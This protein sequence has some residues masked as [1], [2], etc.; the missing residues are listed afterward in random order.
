MVL[1]FQAYNV[2]INV[3]LVGLQKKPEHSYIMDE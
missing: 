3:A 1:F 2:L